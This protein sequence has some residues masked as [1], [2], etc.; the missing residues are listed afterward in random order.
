VKT[1]KYVSLMFI[2]F[3]FILGCLG[4]R[5]SIKNQSA[6]ESKVTQE[7]LRLG[8]SLRLTFDIFLARV[9]RR[10]DPQF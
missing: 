7:K 2:A 1:L 6:D 4:T 9:K 3:V 8:S 5:T 10:L